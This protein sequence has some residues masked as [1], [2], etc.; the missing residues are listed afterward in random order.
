MTIREI[1]SER[2][3]DEFVRKLAPNTFLHSWPWGQ[4]QKKTGEAVRYLG[5]MRDHELAGAALVIT[6]NAR[7]GRHYLIPHGPLLADEADVQ[8]GLSALIGHL[9]QQAPREGAVCLRIAPLLEDAPQLRKVFS[10]LGF[11]PAP[12]HVHAELTWVLDINKSEEE[13][14][15][16]M[17]KTTRH[18]IRKAQG[19]GATADIVTTP[20]G[21]ERFMPLYGATRTR[22]GFVPFSREFLAAQV[23]EFGSRGQLFFSIVRHQGRDLAA[24]ICVQ[25]GNTVFYHHGASRTRGGD[26]PAGQAGPSASHLTQWAAMQEAWRRGATRYNFWGIAPDHEPDHPFAGI[27]VFKKGFGGHAINYLH[28][29]DLPLSPRYWQLWAVEMWRKHRRGF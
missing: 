4:V 8:E 11:R 17:R 29:Q 5:I 24:A 28:A 15:A 27:T 23:E 21:L 20:A 1:T 16:G 22:H 3:W 25:A 18:A 13:L 12:L 6:V 7:R 9:R 19:M 14:L 2:E 26:L 10:D